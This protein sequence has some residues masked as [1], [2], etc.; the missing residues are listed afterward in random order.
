MKILSLFLTCTL[1]MFAETYISS[2][3]IS[4][5]II[6]GDSS[7]EKGS[8][9]SA[10][11]NITLSSSFNKINIDIPANL[12]V[13]KKT[14]TSIALT[15]DDNLLDA[16]RFNVQNSTLFIQAKGGLHSSSGIN[17][18]IN[19]PHLIALNIDGAS[20]INIKGFYEKNFNLLVDGAS[21][22][23]FSVGKIGNLSLKADGSYDINLIQ[24]DIQRAK[25][26]AEGAGN[27]NIKVTDYLDVKLED[28]V[29]M[30]Y[31][32]NPKIKKQ[33]KDIAEL[34]PI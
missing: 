21:D 26:R 5:S 20:D 2:S 16:I 25:I 10:T 1:S 23:S 33:I 13:N 6:T 31:R 15:T 8:G 34:T 27:I 11:K 14:K 19:N 9:I 28:T 17:I 32:G 3:I 7:R 18:H 12:T 4:N 30:H 24:L 22:V 29:E